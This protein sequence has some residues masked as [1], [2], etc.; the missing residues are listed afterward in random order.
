MQGSWRF[1]PD[2]GVYKTRD[3]EQRQEAVAV[4][5]S[6]KGADSKGADEIGAILS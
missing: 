6:T 3:V 2:E 5:E 4:R 1:R